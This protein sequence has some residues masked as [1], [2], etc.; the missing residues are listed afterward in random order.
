[1]PPA[2]IHLDRIDSRSF[3]KRLQDNP[4]VILPVGALEAHGPHLPLGA[5]QIQAEATAEQLGERTGGLLAPSMAYGSCPGARRF[6]GTVSLT[7]SALTSGVAGVLSEFGRMGVRRLLV[8]SGHAERGHMAALREAA[9]LAMQTHPRLKV[10]VLSDYDFVY[11]LRGTAAPATDGHA[12]LLETSRVLHLASHTVGAE[13]PVVARGGSP[14]VP[15]PPGLEE[16]P[17]SVQGDTRMAS[18]ELG[19]RVQAHVLDRLEATVR[20]LLPG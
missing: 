13:R 18:G 2:A 12:G 17:E 3:E 10:V 1:M 14:F 8:L 16:W 4:L 7:L 15:G 19:A 11:E 9:D 5:D 6:P 20:E